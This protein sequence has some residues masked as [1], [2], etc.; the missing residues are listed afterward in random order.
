MTVWAD[1][2]AAFDDDYRV[3]A[4][5]LP[6]HGLSGAPDGDTFTVDMYTGAIDAVVNEARLDRIVLVGHS[7]GVPI[8][9]QY[10]ASYPG[11]VAALVAV[12]GP[13]LSAPPDAEQAA[14]PS[15][16]RAGREAA[17]RSFFV[18]QTSEALREQVLD[19]MLAPSDERAAAILA[20]FFDPSFSF[21]EPVDV[22]T[23]IAIAGNRPPLDTENLPANATFVQMQDTGHFLMM[24][25]PDEFNAQLR[26]FL[27]SIDY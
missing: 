19:L 20:P 25:Q 14:P 2:M 7:M 6:G 8:V 1:Q 21:V 13:D 10:A 11:R 4:L 3:I 23:L 27:E 15:F 26:A 5:D 22:P 18:P 16:D 12:D 24:E 17:I 9:S